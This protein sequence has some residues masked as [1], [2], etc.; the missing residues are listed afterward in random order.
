[1]IWRANLLNRCPEVAGSTPAPG[2]SSFIQKESGRVKQL[3]ARKTGIT[4]EDILQAA[5][6]AAKE[7]IEEEYGVNIEDN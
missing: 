3:L 1:M 4:D 6:Q 5:I 2:T 7:S